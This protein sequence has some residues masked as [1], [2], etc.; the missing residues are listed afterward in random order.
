MKLAHGI[1]AMLVTPFTADY[2][3]NEDALRAEVRWALE[4]GADGIVAT[5]SI[6][7]FLH[8]SESERLRA[9]ECTLE[10]TRRRP[11]DLRGRDDF[12]RHHSRN[13]QLRKACG[14][15]GFRRAAGDSA[16][17]LALR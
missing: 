11:G 6:G 17:L 3:L 9:W 16:L 10:E 12:G 8:L 4:N 14:Q 2:K 7:E 1:L 13:A 5:P 15:D